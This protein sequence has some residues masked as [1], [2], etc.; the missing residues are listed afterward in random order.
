VSD[1]AAIAPRD[2]F[3]LPRLSV[4]CFVDADDGLLVAGFVALRGASAARCG[5]SRT[6]F[7]PSIRSSSW[8]ARA[9]HPS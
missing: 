3:A 7:T 9:E 1:A 4:G 8:E 5:V 6:D 2:V